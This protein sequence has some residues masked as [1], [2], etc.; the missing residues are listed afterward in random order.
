M[1]E[2]LV[3]ITIIGIISTIGYV[4]FDNARDK[5]R[6]A[7]RKQDLAAIR[8]ALTSYYQD[9]DAYP[10]QAAG[11]DEFISSSPDDPWIPD[12]EPYIQKLPKD[13]R[14]TGLNIFSSLASLFQKSIP[15]FLPAAYADTSGK[16][17]VGAS[18]TFLN[19]DSKLASKYT[20]TTNGTITSVRWYG[21]AGSVGGAKDK[22]VILPNKSGAPGALVA[23]SKEVTVYTNCQ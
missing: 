1:I 8:T 21:R 11:T 22:A 13:P 19:R 3:A 14:Q 5:G 10:P 17:T 12:L 15:K 16:T 6:D 7:K 20:L 23:I 2:L 4:N 18:N 9:H